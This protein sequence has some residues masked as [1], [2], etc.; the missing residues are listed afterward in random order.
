[1]FA[2]SV[3]LQSCCLATGPTSG[4]AGMVTGSYRTPPASSLP[5]TAEAAQRCW[6]HQWCSQDGTHLLWW[7]VVM[8]EGWMADQWA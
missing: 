3:P 5:S 2:G 6:L 7:L 1:M 4:W 8:V